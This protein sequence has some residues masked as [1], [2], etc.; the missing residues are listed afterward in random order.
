MNFRYQF[1]RSLLPMQ[2]QIGSAA[3]LFQN[4]LRLRLQFH[5]LPNILE[6]FR[7]VSRNK[8]KNTSSEFSIENTLTFN[9]E[10]AL[11]FNIFKE[12]AATPNFCFRS[13]VVILYPFNG[14]LA[15]PNKPNI[16]Y[17]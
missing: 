5:L 14:F 3:Q 8:M 15:P 12:S 11:S 13:T 2:L 1:S 4:M 17:D 6:H 10:E 7:S 16:F 9:L